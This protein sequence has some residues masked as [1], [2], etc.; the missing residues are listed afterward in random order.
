MNLFIVN[1]AKKLKIREDDGSNL[2]VK[3][4]GKLG[5]HEDLE[6]KVNERT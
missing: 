1:L 5:D 6:K 2:D 3:S 4:E